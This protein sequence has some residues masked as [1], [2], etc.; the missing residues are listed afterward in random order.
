MNDQSRDFVNEIFKEDG[1]LRDGVFYNALGRTL[2]KSL[3]QLSYSHLIIIA[4]AWLF[5]YTV[6][7]SLY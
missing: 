2:C 1:T 4:I 6:F 5:E 3:R 7:K